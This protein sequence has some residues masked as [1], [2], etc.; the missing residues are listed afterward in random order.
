MNFDGNGWNLCKLKNGLAGLGRFEV[1][2]EKIESWRGV[3]WGFWMVV[4]LEIELREWLAR[5]LRWSMEADAVNEQ[6]SMAEF[7]MCASSSIKAF[8]K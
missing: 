1:G 2:R 6:W 8:S 5:K 4:K 3:W 7:F